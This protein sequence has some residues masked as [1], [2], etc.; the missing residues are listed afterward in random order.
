[1]ALRSGGQILVD[2]LVIQGVEQVFCVPGESYLAVLDALHDAPIRTITCRQESGAGIM[3]EAVGKL[4]GRPGIVFATR[5]PGAT[6]AAHAV[7]IAEHDSTPL[8]LFVGQVQRAARG[9]GAF[10]EIDLAALFGGMAKFVTDI[11]DAARIPEILARAFATAMQGRPGPVVLGLPEDMLTDLA[12]VPDAPP[13]RAADSAPSCAQMD[14]LDALLEQ[15]A[16]PLMILGGSGWTEAGCAAIA[17]FA[18]NHALPVAAS[19]RRQ[20]LLPSSHPGYAGDLGLGANPALRRLVEEADLVLLVGGRFSET[21]S[22]RWTLL[23]VPQPRQTLVHVHPGAEELGRVYQAHL[24]ILA[25]PASFALAAAELR[26]NR[27]P[28][29]AARTAAMHQSYLAWSMPA[30]DP[31][32]KFQPA[33]VMAALRDLL[34]EDA[35]VSNGAG[36]YASWVHRYHRYGGWGTQLAPVSGSMGYGV[37]AAIAGKLRHPERLAVSFAGDGC[38]LMNGQ[39]F[40]TAVQENVPIIVIVLDNAMYGTIRMHQETHYPGRVVATNLRNPD[41]AALARAF[42]GHG[43]TVR[44]AGEFAPAFARARDSQKPAIL[45][46]ITAAEAITPTARLSQSG[47]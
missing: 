6:N 2:Q 10:Q 39:E 41:F 33:H 21:P 11:D 29:W 22:L 25:S 8:I 3:A 7:H 30:P 9:R 17:D 47:K 24:P 35:M 5:G 19:F 44:M 16:N 14:E 4:T 12:D 38:F 1:M 20:S 40:A 13:V 34:A 26:P 46:C 23:D 31:A 18:R 42:G 36:N 43:E 27:A 28:A 15:A 37:P 45:H 32:E